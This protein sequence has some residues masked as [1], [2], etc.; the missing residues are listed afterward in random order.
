MLLDCA[1]EPLAFEPPPTKGTTD[2]VAVA[3]WKRAEGV[4]EQKVVERRERVESSSGLSA[5][6]R[7]FIRDGETDAGLRAVSTFRVAAEMKEFSLSHGEDDLIC[8][9]VTDAAL[10]C[11]LSPS[12][13]KRQVACGLERARNTAKGGPPHE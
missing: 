12:E 1:R 7:R 8:A 13:V 2:P 3:D 6:A 5:F 10:D 11:G 4:V 9:I